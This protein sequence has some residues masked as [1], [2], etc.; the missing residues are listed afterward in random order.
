MAVIRVLKAKADKIASVIVELLFL[1][2][3][4][5]VF[6]VSIHDYATGDDLGYGA[7]VHRAL[8]Q[9]A[10]IGAFFNAFAETFKAQYFGWG[11]TWSSTVLWILEPSI[12]G[13]K[14]YII[15]PFIALL[16][17][18]IGI[19][20]ILKE[21]LGVRFG[22]KKE[23][24]SIIV[25]FTVFMIVQYMPYTKGGIFWFPGMAQ[26][27]LAY[28]F[29][30]LSI[31]WILC[32]LRTKEKK[33]F[34]LSCLAMTYL[35]GA[36]YP[37]AVFV[38]LSY[39]VIFLLVIIHKDKE[40]LCNA[41]LLL[42]PIAFETVGVIVSAAAPGNKIRGGS[43]FGFSIGRVVNAVIFAFFHGTINVF[44]FC[45]HVR[46]MILLFA[47]VILI[48]YKCFKVEKCRISMNHPF[49][50]AVSLFLI[51][52]SSYAPEGY[53][54][55]AEAGFSGG[56]YDSYF[57]FFVLL[58]V[59]LLSYLT[60]GFKLYLIGRHNS[61][62]NS[63]TIDRLL[64]YFMLFSLVFC[65]A[66]GKHLIGNSLDYTCINYIRSGQMADFELQMQERLA[67]LEDT[68]ISDAVVPEMN[69]EQGPLMHMALLSDPNAYTNKNT[70][71]FYGKTSVIAI[72]REE[73]LRIYGKK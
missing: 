56:M 36:G 9:H 8:V 33:Y 67:I 15:T 27:T 66:F 34:T 12:W 30:L 71:L 31:C 64:I 25:C 6:W 52:C 5:P 60:C 26:Y 37:E 69:P 44:Q 53:V 21:I 55:T 49:I 7:L 23:A 13:E 63:K 39:A 51:Y 10:S 43:G 73:Y 62:N 2:T 41:G 72:P 61:K 3:L 14:F 19:Y 65:I 24:I 50:A 1:V 4:I 16:S 47:A 45:I 11:G 38:F 54:K 29:S 59:I 20:F 17:L 32:W 70:E 48:S 68:S 22:L 18:F 42:I 57:Y 35:G 28:G 58:S 46:P 40:H